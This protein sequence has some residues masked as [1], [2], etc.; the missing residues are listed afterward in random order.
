M[1]VD[2]KDLKK[3]IG[4]VLSKFDHH[5]LNEDIEVFKKTNAYDINPTAEHIASYLYEFL[6]VP[7]SDLGKGF[8]DGVKLE[9]V[10]VWESEK[11]YAEYSEED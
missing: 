10:K 6:K 9:R 3:I 8:I 5:Y 4:E 2:F 7:V 11:A 1:L